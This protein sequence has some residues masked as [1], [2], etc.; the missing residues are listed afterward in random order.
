MAG[1]MKT[2]TSAFIRRVELKSGK[3][4]RGVLKYT[5]ENGISFISADNLTFDEAKAKAEE[6]KAV[7]CIP[8]LD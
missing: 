8:V 7:A 2:I 1:T 6:I 3:Q 4:W 5:D